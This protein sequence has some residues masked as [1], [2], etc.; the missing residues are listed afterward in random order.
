MWSTFCSEY[1]RIHTTRT[2]LPVATVF[3][4]C[5]ATLNPF[6]AD[7]GFGRGHLWDSSVGSIR[8]S[9]DRPDISIVVASLPK[10]RQITGIFRL[11]REAVRIRPHII[12]SYSNFNSINGDLCEY[13]KRNAGDLRCNPR[14]PLVPSVLKA[15]RDVGG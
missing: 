10:E 15:S 11:L 1:A 13:R 9:I 2:L 3:F 8:T 7:G 6:V 12:S 5:T 4:A 14:V